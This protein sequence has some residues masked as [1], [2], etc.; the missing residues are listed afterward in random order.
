MADAPLGAKATG[1]IDDGGHQLIGVEAALHNG[2]GFPRANQGHGG[3]GRSVAVRRIG[4]G[5]SGNID[6]SLSRCRADFGFGADEQGQNK[7]GLHGR[8]HALKREGI[9]WMGHRNP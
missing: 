8:G 1:P 6:G 2:I 5:P 7:P 4:Y 3:L 9:A